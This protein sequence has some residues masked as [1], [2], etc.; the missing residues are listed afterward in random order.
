MLDGNL[1]CGLFMKPVGKGFLALCPNFELGNGKIYKP[2]PQAIPKQEKW[3][4]RKK[5]V[6]PKPVSKITKKKPTK[7]KRL[8]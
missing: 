3:K 2:E 5:E 8:F 1:W 6:K 4:I 7:Q